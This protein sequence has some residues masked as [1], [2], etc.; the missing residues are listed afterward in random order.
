M[1]AANDEDSGGKVINYTLA[2]KKNKDNLKD[3]W[4]IDSEIS[5]HM[6]S[7]TKMFHEYRL[8]S[9]KNWVSIANE[10]HISIVGQKNI[11]LF[12]KYNIRNILHILTCLPV[13]LGKSLIVS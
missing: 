7:N 8:L 13:R 4:I 9:Y 6:T 3:K 1:G 11:S 2:T 5:D 10:S 12:D